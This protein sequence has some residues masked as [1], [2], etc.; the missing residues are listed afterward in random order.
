MGGHARLLRL[1]GAA[2]LALLLALP[3]CGSM[4]ENMN[5]S[6]RITE[7]T[8]SAVSVGEAEEVS[9]DDLAEAMLRAGFTPEEIV[10]YGAEIHSALATSGGAQV[11]QGKIVSAI[12]AVHT[13]KLYVTSRERGTFVQPLTYAVPAATIIQPPPD[14]LPLPPS[15]P[16]VVVV[17]P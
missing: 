9:A 7:E 12:F 11:R 10:K 1:P 16:D 14:V 3:G 8:V 5:R 15:P 4:S 13:G 2:A 17:K 6:I